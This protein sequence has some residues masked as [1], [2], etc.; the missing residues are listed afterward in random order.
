MS[1]ATDTEPLVVDSSVI[2]A[3]TFQRKSTICRDLSTGTAWIEDPTSF[4]YQCSLWS[5]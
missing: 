5:K 4:T 2:V 1:S 3:S